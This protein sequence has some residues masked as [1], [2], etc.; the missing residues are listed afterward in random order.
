MVRR[1]TLVMVYALMVLPALGSSQ[2]ASSDSVRLHQLFAQQWDYTMREYPE[3]AT[4]VGYG[5][6]PLNVLDA[7][8]RAWVAS[9]R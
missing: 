8:I 9:V 4:S 6:L 1:S 7:R 5:A 2:Q 3:F